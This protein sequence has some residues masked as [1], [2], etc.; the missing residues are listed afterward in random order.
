MSHV[1]VIDDDDCDGC[2]QLSVDEVELSAVIEA[3]FK[4]VTNATDLNQVSTTIASTEHDGV[5]P[6]KKARKETLVKAENAGTPLS[7]APTPAAEATKSAVAAASVSAALAAPPLQLA[8]VAS[9]KPEIKLEIKPEGESYWGRRW[10]GGAGGGEESGG[11]GGG[12]GGGG[13]GG[14]GGGGGTEGGGGG[15][16]CYRNRTRARQ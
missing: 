14:G 12:G 7:P 1:V 13:D 6:S 8:A 11:R 10:G 4:D 15:V 2:S 3:S 5:T 16:G 9:V